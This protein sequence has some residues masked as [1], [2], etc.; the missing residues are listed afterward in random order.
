ME[1]EKNEV[2]NTCHYMCSNMNYMNVIL[3]IIIIISIYHFLIK[4]FI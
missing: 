1:K 3:L 4:K 2:K